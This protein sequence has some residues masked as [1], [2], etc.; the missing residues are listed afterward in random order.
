M[1]VVA[2]A[3]RDPREQVRAVEEGLPHGQVRVTVE[4][5]AQLAA[6]RAA[7]AVAAH[8]IAGPH[9]PVLSVRGAQLR[10][11]A[12]IVLREIGQLAAELDGDSWRGLRHLAQQ[13][14]E[15]VLGDQL[16]GLKWHGAIVDQLP[17]GLQLADRR[18]SV[19]DEW[20]PGEGVGADEDI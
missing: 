1:V 12:V 11:Y 17:D 20:G 16:R 10:G 5:D 8:E 9:R 19:V 15:G 13:R 2:L 3:D 7:G 18:V 4:L 6:D 14:L